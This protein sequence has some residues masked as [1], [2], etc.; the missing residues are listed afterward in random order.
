VFVE[1]SANTHNVIHPPS[2]SS[3]Q[4][5]TCFCQ[6]S[7]TKTLFYLRKHRKLCSFKFHICRSCLS[8]FETRP[9][10]FEHLKQHHQ[11]DESDAA[12]KPKSPPAAEEGCYTMYECSVSGCGRLFG[13]VTRLNAHH[14]SHTKPYQCGE[15]TQSFSRRGDL[16]VHQ[17]RR[18][19]KRASKT[20][21][22]A[23][24]KLA[25]TFCE[26]VFK[27][28]SALSKHMECMHA[29]TPRQFVCRRCHKK[30]HRKDELQSHLRVHLAP[31]LRRSFRCTD[32]ALQCSTKSNLNRH[33]KRMHAM[34]TMHTHQ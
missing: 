5:T 19:F 31:V 17:L 10:L 30:F 29:A 16:K 2:S 15:C 23:R 25:C 22:A 12:P 34:H 7:V 14:K 9:Q 27:T 20:S 1:P 4:S 6:V 3:A 21:T 24:P 13:S 11:R 32:C 26:E 33:R 8:I 28:R 18:H